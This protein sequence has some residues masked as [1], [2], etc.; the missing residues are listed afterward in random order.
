MI[1]YCGRPAAAASC[2]PFPY[3]VPRYA[4]ETIT[5][6]RSL[7]VALATAI[8]SQSDSHADCGVAKFVRACG[9]SEWIWREIAAVSTKDTSANPWEVPR[10]ASEQVTRR[11]LQLFRGRYSSARF[12]AVGCAGSS[13]IRACQSADV[14]RPHATAQRMRASRVRSPREGRRPFNQCRDLDGVFRD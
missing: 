3:I 14:A 12:A 5:G 4:R 9:R 11:L 10:H 7:G 1:A 6:V 2:D 8:I 13:M